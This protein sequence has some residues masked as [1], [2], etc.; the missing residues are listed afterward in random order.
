LKVEQ[1]KHLTL[2][3]QYC[4]WQ[5]RSVVRAQS[6]GVC[7]HFSAKASD[8]EVLAGNIDRTVSRGK[9]IQSQVS[10]VYVH[11]SYMPLENYNDVALLKVGNNYLRRNSLQIF[12]SCVLTL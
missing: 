6:D 3:C 10:Q 7:L 12:C 4:W 5:I 8:I 1:W 11:G 9:W 2:L